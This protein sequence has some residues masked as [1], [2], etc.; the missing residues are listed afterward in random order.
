MGLVER[1]EPEV[2]GSRDTWIETRP[3][4]DNNSIMV[5]HDLGKH[6]YCTASSYISLQSRCSSN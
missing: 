6:P 3:R 5:P 4:A 2:D 1:K